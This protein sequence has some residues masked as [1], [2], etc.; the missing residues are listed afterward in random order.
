[1]KQESQAKLNIDVNIGMGFVKD[2]TKLKES[3]V[4][5]RKSFCL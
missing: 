2:C 4:K 3:L 5:Q 1:M